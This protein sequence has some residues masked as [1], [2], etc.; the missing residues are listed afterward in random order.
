MKNFVLAI[1]LFI[2]I[3]TQAQVVRNYALEVSCNST[4]I[5]G[6][7]SQLLF[8]WKYRTPAAVTQN[9][10]KKSKTAY[11]WGSAYKSIP[12]TDSTFIDTILTGNAF[13][14]MFEKDTMPNGYS[15]YGYILAGSFVPAPT[16]RGKIIIIADSTNKTYLDTVFRTF[17]NDLIGDGWRIM[18][19]Y[20]S[21]STSV[22]AIK[23][24]IVTDYLLDMSNVKSVLLFGEISVPYS[25]DFKGSGEFPPDGHT[26]IYSPPSHEGAWPADA[27]YGDMNVTAW[28]DISVVNSLGARSQNN[29]SIGDG[30]F[31]QTYLPT[32]LE[33][34]VGRIDLSDMTSFSKSQRELLKQ[35]LKRD[36]NFRHKLF[37]VTERGLI[38][39]NFGVISGLED[40]GNN[41]YRN[42]SP[43]IGSNSTSALDYL[44]NLDNNDY[45]FSYG[46][47][48]GSYTS[49]GGIGTTTN[50]ASGT[51][52]VL[53]V[54]TS[55]F[56]SYF[57]DWDNTNS[58]LRAPLAADGYVLTSCWAGRPHWY[59][60]H[61]GLGETV[62]FSTIRTQNNYNTSTGDLIYPN[63]Q[64]S[65]LDIHVALMG[66]PTLRMHPVYTPA[67]LVAIQQNCDS[68]VLLRWTASQD[69]AVHNY[70][71]MRAKH[72][73]SSFSIL[74]TTA[75]T[76]Y[77]DLSALASN[78]YMVRALKLQQGFSG[79]YYNMSQ[80]LFDTVVLN[81]AVP[82][83]NAGRDTAVCTNQRVLLGKN[84]LNNSSVIYTW[85]PVSSSKDT[86][87]I[88]VTSSLPYYITATDTLNGCLKSDTVNITA[89][90]LPLNE[91]LSFNYSSSCGDTIQVL[92]TQNN[93]STYIYSWQFNGGNPAVQS[94]AGLYN[95]STVTYN[96]TG[97]SVIKLTVSN[98]TTG[99]FK[100]DS[101][102]N[103]ISCIPLPVELIS[104]ECI[105]TINTFKLSWSVIEDLNNNGYRIEQSVDGRQY[106]AV[107]FLNSDL[108]GSGKKVE[109]IYDL[110]NSESK[111]FR[112]WQINFDG[113]ET[114]I[115]ECYNNERINF[116][117]LPNP[118]D[119]ELLIE[120]EHDKL[121]INITLS[122]AC[123]RPVYTLLSHDIKTT[124]N[125]SQLVAGIYLLNISGKGF[126][127]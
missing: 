122:D 33:L 17:R 113:R 97:S 119:F 109:Y 30:K 63:I 82:L 40:V 54:F 2:T 93:P 4:V 28:T 24:L 47:G 105:K 59:F 106:K 50:F 44:S 19:H 87:S 13:E 91:S 58:F 69:T 11:T 53:T 31:D 56:G 35:Y 48:G 42:N 100:I 70:L 96:A 104:F 90:T 6:S 121:P 74:G 71:I 45:L 86:V 110:K 18:L 37:S 8:S 98:G 76:Y 88:S 85:M 114:L 46:C 29:N 118:F 23:S 12:N 94:S 57:G 36:H 92:S 112:V 101:V 77:S 102:T 108:T 111:Y 64:A 99:C 89:N 20:V 55:L 68:K 27:Y 14:Y 60:H 66:D 124:L 103:L 78:V 75:N 3:S 62:G 15:A 80:G 9:V 73:D 95:P 79:T 26:T 72:I 1:L 10:Y 32:L 22:T 52:S 107:G 83:V 127:E 25:G 21:P 67:N 41:A 43:T 115:G 125:T 116:N 123:G 61:M 84:L 65:P 7:Q 117:V 51:Q 34:Q 120:L 38:D 5:N 16:Y 39:D 126:N 49:A 81:Y